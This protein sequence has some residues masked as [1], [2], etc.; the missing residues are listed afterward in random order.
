[1]SERDVSLPELPADVLELLEGERKA[2]SPS[3]QARARVLQRVHE[4]MGPLDPGPGDG[5]AGGAPSGSAGAAP[6]SATPGA[7]GLGAGL[8]TA[9][10]AV[11]AA[12]AGGVGVGAGVMKATAPAPAPPK[13]VYVE[14]PVPT[15]VPAPKPV[16]PARSVTATRAPGER[17]VKVE[18]PEPSPPAASTRR[19]SPR[20]NARLERPLIDRAQ[21]ALGRRKPKSALSALDQHRRRYPKGAL[22]EEREALR[23]LALL[24]DG[25]KKAA[26]R[27]AQV[28]FKR[29][30]RS[31]FGPTLKTNLSS[32]A[33]R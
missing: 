16:Q 19:P 30:P 27:A 18:A 29:Y 14:V 11:L 7:L 33:P 3:A 24:Q 23:V 2:A 31:L 32:K 1:M 17:T 5:N 6:S 28:F 20:R 15:P 12:F 26:Q 21:T 25:Q 22:A 10:V 4:S 8:N 13:I 9:R